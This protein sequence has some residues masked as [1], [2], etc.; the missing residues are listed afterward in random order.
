MQRLFYFLVKLP[1]A[2]RLGK[3]PVQYPVAGR[4]QRNQIETRRIE[5]MRLGKRGAHDLRL[6]QRQRAA[7]RTDPKPF[8]GL[9][10]AKERC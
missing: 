10:H 9:R 3:R 7:A 8:C 2:A 4:A 6:P 5:P 1:F